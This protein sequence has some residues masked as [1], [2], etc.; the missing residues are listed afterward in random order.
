MEIGKIDNRRTFLTHPEIGKR[1]LDM[2]KEHPDYPIAVL[3][4]E[5]ANAGD[6]YW[7]YATNVKVEVGEILDCVS[8]WVNDEIVTT[9]RDRFEEEVED[10]VWDRLKE[11]LGRKPTDEEQDEAVKAVLKAHEPY[12]VKCITITADN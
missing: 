6:Y 3:V 5:E 11:E 12:W 7:M 9:D 8:E 4:G 10:K 2:V 1:I